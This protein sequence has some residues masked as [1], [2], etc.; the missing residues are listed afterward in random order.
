MTQR[1]I[2]LT[3]AQAAQRRNRIEEE[4]RA[5]KERRFEV[6]VKLEAAK[7]K[8]DDERKKSEEREREKK[9]MKQ[10]TDELSG[11][12]EKKN[13]D[14]LEPEDEEDTDNIK[15]DD[16]KGRLK[17]SEN[18]EDKIENNIEA[19]IE[20]KLDQQF[21][22]MT[23]KGDEEDDEK[24]NDE[25]KQKENDGVKEKEDDGVKQKEQQVSG[26]GRLWLAH[27]EV[28]MTIFGINIDGHDKE[29]LDEIFWIDIEELDD[30]TL[31][32]LTRKKSIGKFK[33]TRCYVA[34]VLCVLS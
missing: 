33:K 2:V 12:G 29:E 34:V 21:S 13:E 20:D 7:L 26:R 4:E 31:E 19:K 23:I 14:I 18:V 15:Q 9:R 30:G 17:T 6:E 25:S 32:G 5:D 10:I 22:K 27:H 8:A 11:N 3:E 28:D 16:V 24:E 1:L